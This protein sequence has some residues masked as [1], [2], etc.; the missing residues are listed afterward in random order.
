MEKVLTDFSISLIPDEETLKRGKEIA[1]KVFRVLRKNKKFQIDRTEILGSF[2]KKTTISAHV[3]LDCVVFI[4]PKH[5]VA[6]PR[7]EA[8]DVFED[9]LQM[10]EGL[11]VNFK[12]IPEKYKKNEG[13]AG[14]R[15]RGIR[16]RHRAR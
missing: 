4:N 16:L 3:D 12:P 7:D 8:F 14:S 2:G 5:G 13:C 1:D 11:E 10:A 15:N 6:V 9:V